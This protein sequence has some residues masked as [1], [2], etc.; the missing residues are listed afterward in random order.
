MASAQLLFGI[1]ALQSNFI[2]SE[3]LVAAFDA[4]V[5][6]KRQTLAEILVRQNAISPAEQQLLERLVGKFLQRHAGGAEK[7]L[8]ALSSTAQF[9]P[10]LARIFDQDLQASLGQLG[11][12]AARAEEAAICHVGALASGGASAPCFAGRGWLRG[13][14]GARPWRLAPGCN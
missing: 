12:N 4:W 9:C 5:R 13:G 6:D 3:Q 14:P 1:I 7:S 11:A 8:A 10:E 2:T